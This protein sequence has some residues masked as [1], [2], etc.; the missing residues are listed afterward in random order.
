MLSAL[1]SF[2][3]SQVPGLEYGYPSDEIQGTQQAEFPE[4]PRLC[5]FTHPRKNRKNSQL[6]PPTAICSRPGTSLAW[7]LQSLRLHL[8]DPGDR[9]V[10]SR[11]DRNLAFL[12]QAL[13]PPESSGIY[14]KS[15][16]PGSQQWALRLLFN[17]P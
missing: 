16:A 15:P 2:W 13:H 14:T 3:N 9:L 4:S 8:M 12:P 5:F 11:P 1:S 7:Q 17:H 10:A 6:S